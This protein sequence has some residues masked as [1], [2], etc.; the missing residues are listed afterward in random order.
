MD[1]FRFTAMH[2][3]HDLR[4]VL[5]AI[6]NCLETMR[7]RVKGAPLPTEVEHIARLL[8][9]GVAITDELLVSRSL[10][11]AAPFVEVNR[12]LEGL[13]GVV[14]TIV[15]A[16][17][18]LRTKLGAPESRVYAQPLDLERILL[19][20]VFNAAAAMPTGGALLIE[21]NVAP[22]AAGASADTAP[23]GNL[24]LTIRDTGCGIPESQLAE[25]IDP[26]AKP[27]QDG[28]GLGLASIALIL[29]RIG[30]SFSI[31]SRPNEGTVVSIALPLWPGHGTQPH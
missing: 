6:A 17:V 25:V 23:F 5:L 14:G 1:G 21:T 2:L 22:T 8:E 19:N 26:M 30:G 20:A 18:A 12:L 11:P 27:R 24:R 9:T 31:E 10:H 3:I 4:L 29:T 28:S 15:G 16:D 7:E 13:D